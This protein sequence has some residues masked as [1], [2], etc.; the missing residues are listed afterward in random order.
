MV[1]GETASQLLTACRGG[2]V[3]AGGPS[4][5]PV[6]PRAISCHLSLECRSDVTELSAAQRHRRGLDQEPKP[7]PQPQ[8][9]PHVHAAWV[10]PKC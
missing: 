9:Q 1:A 8:P 7:E 4:A 6:Y 5:G 3:V 2:E 10:Y